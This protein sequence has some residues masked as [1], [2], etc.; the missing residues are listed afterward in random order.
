MVTGIPLLLIIG[1]ALLGL[2][3]LTSYAKVH[4]FL[5]LLFTSIAMA[6]AIQIPAHQLVQTLNQGFGKL[7]SYI[8]IVVILGSIMGVALERS[9]GAQ[10]IAEALFNTVG[11]RS[12]R[13]A[14]ILIGAITGIP[15]FCDTG[16]VILSRLNP[17]LARRSGVPTATLSLGLAGGLYTT[18]TLVPPTPGPIAAAGNLGLE[19]QLG[20][21]MIFGGITS[22]VV[23]LGIW[24]LSHWLGRRIQAVDEVAE[25][26]SSASLPSLWLSLLP[27]L[28]PVGMISG[29]TILTLIVMPGPAL[30]WIKLIC[31]PLLALTLGMLLSFLLHGSGNT[32]DRVE[33]WIKTGIEVSGSILILTGAGGILGAVIQSS[34]L[35]TL[36]RDWMA[37]GNVSGVWILAIGFCVAALMKTAQGSSTSALIIASAMMAPIAAAAGLA[38]APRL[39]LLVVAI[40]GGSMTVSHANDS[41]FW[42]VSQFSG[43]TMSQAYKS[44]TP[45]TFGMGVIALMTSMLIFLILEQG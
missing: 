15:V 5:A 37:G 20:W 10:R 1:V 27:I 29:G 18:H 23:I 42:V 16:F 14:M 43:M 34:P 8:G 21:V 2:V 12:P 31:H 36:M 17:F 7:M 19:D 32:T 22:V 26:M 39:A 3:W 40:G 30:E 38:D 45:L 24:I 13:L 28:L 11:R 44:Y 9:G 35:E 33:D 4:P 25:E 41:Y 6:L